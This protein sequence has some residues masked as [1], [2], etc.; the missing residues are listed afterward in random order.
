MDYMYFILGACF[1]FIGSNLLIDNSRLIA[2]SLGISP[3]II[4]LTIVAFGTSLP[5]L[6]VSLVASFSGESDIV[7]GNVI[8]SNIANIALVL[9]IVSIWK[10]I[11]FQ[12]LDLK[13]SLVYIVA[14]STMLILIVIGNSLSFISGLGLLALFCFYIYSQ[15]RIIKSDDTLEKDKNIPFS[16]RYIIYL[17]MGIFLL[18]WGSNLFI[19]GAIGV[20][21]SLGVPL[22]VISLSIV[23]LGT[24]I[25]ELATSLIAIKKNEHNLVI[26]SILGSNIINIVL[27]L[28]SSII[29]NPI[30][31]Y[32]PD[33]SIMY[34]TKIS[35]VF[36][37]IVTILLL[38]II[39][40]KKDINRLFGFL[41][42]IIYIIFIYSNFI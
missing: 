13:N 36:M 1:I 21:T 30:N 20:A 15:F 11:K 31:V 27:V 32:N 19:N 8:G 23:A 35:L 42:V 3:F 10:T 24:S 14:S 4:G 17:F 41:L 12:Y 38:S 7:L 39:L 33:L 5:E 37:S 34:N 26:G 18:G 16:I 9:A 6:I 25:P 2:L 22:I 29:I 28:G 40:L